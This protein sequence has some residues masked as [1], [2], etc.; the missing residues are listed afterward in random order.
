MGWGVLRGDGEGGREEGIS[1]SRPN[2]GLSCLST[3]SSLTWPASIA[4]CKPGK[5]FQVRFR[6][7][8]NEKNKIPSKAVAS[9]WASHPNFFTISSNAPSWASL[10][11]QLWYHFFQ[12]AFISP[13]RLNW[14]PYSRRPYCT[15]MYGRPPPLCP[16]YA[17]TLALFTVKPRT[18]RTPSSKPPERFHL[19][20]C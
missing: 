3:S 18:W 14:E 15:S 6:V 12:E 17:M 13:L 2:F 8:Q 20:E 11:V 10:R 1:V 7:C 19:Y 9:I 4:G 5:F 16:H